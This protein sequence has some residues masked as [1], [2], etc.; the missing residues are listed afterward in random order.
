MIVLRILAYLLVIAGIGVALWDIA[1]YLNDST[2]EGFTFTPVGTLWCEVECSSLQM[3]QPVITREEH[4]NA[5][6]FWQN[7]LQPWVLERP[8]AIVFAVFGMVLFI[9]VQLLRVFIGLRRERRDRHERR[10]RRDSDL[11]RN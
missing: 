8:A 6:L 10:Q 11:I 2:V 9:L 7:F 4:L 3:L 1:E 5:P